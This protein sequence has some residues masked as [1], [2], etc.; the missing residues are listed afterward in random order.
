MLHRLAVRLRRDASPRTFSGSDHGPAWGCGR[1]TSRARATSRRASCSPGPS[2]SLARRAARTAAAR[3]RSPRSAARL[4]AARLRSARL[5]AAAP[6]RT[7]RARSTRV[8]E[9]AEIR[10]GA[11]THHPAPGDA[12]RLAG[13]WSPGHTRLAGSDVDYTEPAKHHTVTARHRGSNG[14]DQRV[15]RCLNGGRFQICRLHRPVDEIRL[16]HADRI[17]RGHAAPVAVRLGHRSATVLSADRLPMGC[18][19]SAFF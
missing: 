16:H 19:G 10:R 3:L 11:E 7:G 13:A 15:H 8:V 14:F 6:A 4:A 17:L 2:L 18:W 9:V 5:A 12:H 1:I